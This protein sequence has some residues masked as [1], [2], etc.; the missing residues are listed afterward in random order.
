MKISLLFLLFSTTCIAGQPLWKKW[1]AYSVNDIVQGYY[2]E[3]AEI[4]TIKKQLQLNQHWWEK[5]LTGK[6][7]KETFIGA[8]S[9]SEKNLKP[10]AFYV[11][12]REGN[13]TE[14]YEGR[15][16]N[17]KLFINIKKIG[18]NGEE[19]TKKQFNIK[20]DTFLSSMFS[21]FLAQKGKAQQRKPFAYNAILEDNTD[22]SFSPQEGKAQ[23]LAVTEKI[24]NVDCFKAELTIL[25]I[26]SI[27]WITKNGRLC[28]AISP[29]IGTKIT[30][31][32]EQEAKAAIGK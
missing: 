23:L 14:N 18:T 25:N 13:L 21:Y 28:K 17:N 7:N 15:F 3:E 11:E 12:K 6:F 22:A 5:S 26:P 1:Y 2:E 10:I 9:S 24:E 16:K 31:I 20:S 29:T 4:D 8:T 27:W 32:P 19:S 30:T